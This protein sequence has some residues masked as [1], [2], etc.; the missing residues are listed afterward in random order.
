M[1]PL[2]DALTPEEIQR[3]IEELRQD[4]LRQAALTF[5]AGSALRQ[6]GVTL[7][8]V[9]CRCIAV[10]GSASEPL[11]GEARQRKRRELDANIDDCLQAA[12]RPSWCDREYEPR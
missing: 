10:P 12:G 2:F 7:R 1:S 6:L 11:R 5:L 3:V 9:N 8:H 4:A